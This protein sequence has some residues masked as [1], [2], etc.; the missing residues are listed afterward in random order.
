VEDALPFSVSRID[1]TVDLVLMSDR[2]LARLATPIF[3]KSPKAMRV[4]FFFH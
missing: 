1:A 2:L 3:G 4:R